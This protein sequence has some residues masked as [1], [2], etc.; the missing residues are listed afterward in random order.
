MSVAP[1]KLATTEQDILDEC[2]ER[3]A[4]AAEAESTNRTEAL[5]D[6]KF[7]DGEQWDSQ[8]KNGREVDGRPCLT[9][10]LTD[11]V[12]R[13][14]TNALRENRPK[15]KCHPVGD[16][17]DVQTAKVIN[18][19]IRHIEASS[20]AD[21]AYDTAVESAVRNGWGYW[22]VN[23]Q[24]VGDD[25]FDQDLTIER[26]RNPFTVFID[27]ASQSPD[28]SDMEWAVVETMMPRIEYRERFK[29]ADPTGWNYQA[30]GSLQGW[31]TKESIRV[32]EYWR[33][34]RKPDTLYLLSD[35]RKCFRGD[36][37]KDDAL[38]A[39]GI[40]VLNKRTLQR[41][42]VEW[43][44]CSATAILDQRDWPGRYIPIVPCYGRETDL[45]GR[46]NRKGVT[47]D[48]R[49]PARMFNYAET[50]KT[51]T[52]AL[53]PKAPW[54]IAEG[55]MEGFEGAWRDANRKPVVAL[56]YKPVQNPDGS[57]APP[58]M[59]QEPPTPASGFTEW[60]QS[61]QS[62]FMAVAG[63]PHDPNQD[64]KGEVVSGIALQRRQGLSD[65]SHFDFYDNQTRSMRHTGTIL[66]DLLPHY[67]DTQR[68]TRIIGDDGTPD[69]A[70]LNEK[71]R[72]P[73]TMAIEKVK[74]DVTVGRYD[75][76]MDVGPGYQT[77][78]EEAAESMM[79][80]LA[81]PLGELTAKAAGDI[82]VRSMDFPDAETIADRMAAMIPG[83]QIDKNSDIPPK[84]QMMIAGLQ[85]QLKQANQRSMAL[86][87]ELH[88]KHH[89]EQIRQDGEDKRLQFKEQAE[90]ERTK[91]KVGAQ[92]HDTHVK[93]VTQH[94]VAEIS[95]AVQL[96]NTHAEAE[97][98]RKAAAELLKHADKAVERDE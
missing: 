51:E 69:V 37:P 20:N 65:I 94:D 35:G 26:I 78:R 79:Q 10:N 55:Q 57:M 49:D 36:K 80:L 38:Q 86:E 4:L 70:T 90:T 48:L 32:V 41:K 7:A 89:L 52:Y 44:M 81:T 5:T 11:A 98:N 85:D 39:A 22:R 75:I 42:T 56:P 67:Y 97:H 12:I 2:R 95:G 77:K 60:S 92:V 8:V 31:T 76:V 19:L 54:L 9:I 28:G 61:S 34:A 18:G 63:M 40:S 82:V 68:I 23:S 3:L 53:Q 25:S 30:Q 45:N 71:V 58:P 14:I 6:L 17:A 62:N 84:A 1:D 66:L 33:I 29:D 88:S 46:I 83:A 24:Y 13:R 50:A 43:Y 93:A 72:N 74:N 59:R 15:I 27:P 21:L 91:M 87:L 47:R 73:E 64:A 96:M 16:G